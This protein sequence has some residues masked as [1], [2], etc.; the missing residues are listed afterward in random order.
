M[1]EIDF[2]TDFIEWIKILINKQ[3]SCIIKGSKTSKH[4]KLEKGTRHS[5]LISAY[6][7]IAVLE[8]GFRVVKGTPNIEFIDTACVGDTK[9]F[10]KNTESAINI[11]ETFE[12][13]S[14]FFGLGFN[15]RKSKCDI[16]GIC[17]LKGVIIAFCSIR[18]V[19]PDEDT[20]KRIIIINHTINNL[21]MTIISKSTMQ[22]LKMC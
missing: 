18:C 5:G 6:L 3:G 8:I 2:M 1:K 16:V 7:L 14:H 21:L 17:V 22:K 19:K 9:F 4:L 15:S 10:P 11:L 13:F 20:V 12:H